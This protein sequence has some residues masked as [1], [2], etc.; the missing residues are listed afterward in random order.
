MFSVNNQ[1]RALD[2]GRSVNA[3]LQRAVDEK[4]GRCRWVAARVK[5][6]TGRDAKQISHRLI[7][8]G[9]DDEHTTAEQKIAAVNERWKYGSLEALIGGFAQS[10]Q[11]KGGQQGRGRSGRGK[12]GE[13]QDGS[14]MEEGGKS[15]EG[16][17]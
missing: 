1:G 5:V 17:V 16:K 8:G 15:S 3:V 11:E 6:P 4:W 7:E 14:E 9:S 12:A 2:A 13:A 10:K